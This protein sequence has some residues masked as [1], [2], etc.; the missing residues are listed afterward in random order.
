[1][2]EVWAMGECNMSRFVIPAILVG[3]LMFWATLIY[4]FL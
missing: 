1:M 3:S 4:H 2:Y